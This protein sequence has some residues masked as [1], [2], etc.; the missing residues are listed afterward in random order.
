MFG[1]LKARKYLPSVATDDR[2]QYF[3]SPKYC[4]TCQNCENVT[5][6]FRIQSMRR[7]VV[8]LDIKL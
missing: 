5:I 7:H 8:F 2:K 6:I 4:L 3:Q 1:I